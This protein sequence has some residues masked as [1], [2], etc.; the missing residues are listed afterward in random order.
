MSTEC[1]RPVRSSRAVT[2]SIPFASMRKV[3]AICGYPAGWDFKRAQFEAREAAGILGHLALALQN[4]DIDVGL[5]VHRGGEHLGHAG[6]DGGVAVDQSF[7]SRRRSSRFRATAAPRRAAACRAG[8]PSERWPGPR[9]LERTTSSGL[10]EHSGS[11]PNIFATSRRT[12]GI[13]VEPPTSTTASICAGLSF[14]SLS[15][16]RHR[17]SVRSTNGFASCSSCARVSFSRRLR[18]GR[19]FR[20]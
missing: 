15:A 10:I 7:P 16:S 19:E 14:A 18:S 6:R 11:R 13:R 4:M 9:R 12:I 5:I 17:S 1:S 8:C 3:T 2:F 20:V